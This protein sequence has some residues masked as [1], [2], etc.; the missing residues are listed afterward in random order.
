MEQER[1]R[2]TEQM[3]RLF[4]NSLK[5]HLTGQHMKA[6]D[7]VITK[8]YPH[9]MYAL[10]WMSN[11]ENSKNLGMKGGILADDMGLGKTLTVLSLIMTNF[12]DGRP[13]GKP[14]F[15]FNRYVSLCE[16]FDY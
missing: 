9:Q 15:G 5:L 3:S 14:M 4:E 10:A 16:D 7:A 12:H 6:C 1:D 11:R 2:I 8:L 13:M